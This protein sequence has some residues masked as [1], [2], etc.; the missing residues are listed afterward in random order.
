MFTIKKEI[1]K[2]VNRRGI[3]EQVEAFRVCGLAQEALDG[4]S[5]QFSVRAKARV[6]KFIRASGTLEVAINDFMLGNTIRSKKV[7]IIKTVNQRM[8][9]D[10]VG[11][12]RYR[13]G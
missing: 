13:L 8:G 1:R 12:I 7:E 2:A 10:Y 5:R 11:R 4:L 6:K 9:G 3:M